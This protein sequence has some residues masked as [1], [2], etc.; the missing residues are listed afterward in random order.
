MRVKNFDLSESS[1]PAQRKR[2]LSLAAAESE[3]VR[4][5]RRE[6]REES[7]DCGDGGEFSRRQLDSETGQA[8]ISEENGTLILISQTY[9]YVFILIHLSSKHILG[10]GLIYEKSIKQC[11]LSLF[12]DN[13]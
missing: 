3:S 7:E 12:F 5:W 2:L 1:S 4:V 8:M 9:A 13:Y 11:T 10:Q 6:S